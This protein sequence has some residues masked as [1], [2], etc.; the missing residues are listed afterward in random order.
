MLLTLVPV[1][2]A[3]EPASTENE[4]VASTEPATPQEPTTNDDPASV[5]GDQGTTESAKGTKDDPFTTVEAYNAA[6][7]ENDKNG[8]DV[9]L[10][11]RGTEENPIIFGTKNTDADTL[12]G[13]STQYN[14][15]SLTNTQSRANPPKLHL[16]LEWCEFYGNTTND[17]SNSSFMYLPNCQS[18]TIDNCT[19]D[20]GTNDLKYG[21]NWNLCGI[22]NSEVSNTN[23]TFTGNYEKKALK[24]NQ[25]NG[26]DDM[27]DDMNEGK[28]FIKGCLVIGGTVLVFFAFVLMYGIFFV[29]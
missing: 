27:A 4:P 22:Q 19:F 5:E 15:F 25:R 21:I 9:Y 13:N 18:L 14:T 20:A 29:K 26:A 23:S 11:I 2:F 7:K 12:A 28:K 6:V 8:E 1:A 17:Q 24:L 16:T 3:A 10:T